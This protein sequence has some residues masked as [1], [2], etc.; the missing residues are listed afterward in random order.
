MNASIEDATTALLKFNE[1]Y[2]SISAET[3]EELIRRRL[4][5][6]PTPEHWRFGDEYNGTTR[7]IDGRKWN[8]PDNSGEEWHKLIGLD[9]V[10]RNDRKHVFFVIEGS[11]DALAAAEFAHRLGILPQIGIACAIGSGYRPIQ[12][13]MEQLRGRRVV[14][15]GDN[16]AVGIE[17]I[18]IVSRA[19]AE[20][21]VDHVVFDYSDMPTGCKDFY[22]A[23]TKL[24]SCVPGY[25]VFPTLSS[26]TF[27]SS[28]LPSYC[29]TVQLFNCSTQETGEVIGVTIE[30]FVAPYAVTQKGTGNRKSFDLAR[31]VKTTNANITMNELTAI[32]DQW[33]SK[34]LPFLPKDADRDQSLATFMRQLTRV[35]FMDSSLKAACVR[36]RSAPPPLVPALDGNVEATM[37]AALCRELQRDAGGR[38]FICP[39][40]VVQQFLNLRWPVQARW[41]LHQLELNGVIECVDRGT[42]NTTGK[43]GKAT[44]WRYKLPIDQ[45]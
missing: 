44:M 34:S 24:D 9:D 30:Q 3:V 7:R 11:T 5:H 15:I 21:G 29:S 38:A 20:G 28:S 45:Q 1:S 17:T 43:K 12:D 14:V 33:F 4:F 18:Q 25:K 8:R 37:L 6:L 35:R 31:A 41:V 42:P 23:L 19:L 26:T 16:D 39:V 27:F 40:N 2:P 22:D 32:F 10:V 13:E 36:A